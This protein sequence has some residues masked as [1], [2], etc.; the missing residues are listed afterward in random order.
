MSINITIRKG[1]G[2]A[3]RAK[4]PCTKVMKYNYSKTLTIRDYQYGEKNG[5][6]KQFQDLDTY[7][8]NLN[9]S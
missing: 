2:I 1:E 9:C 4:S 8:F 6:K 3:K 5:N 7:F